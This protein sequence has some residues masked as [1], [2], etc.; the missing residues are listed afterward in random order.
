M[1]LGLGL[2]RREDGAADGRGPPF[3][4]REVCERGLTGGGDLFCEGLDGD[5]WRLREEVGGESGGRGADTRG[6]GRRDGT[7]AAGCR[8]RAFDREYAGGGVLEP[9][10]SAELADLLRERL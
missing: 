10:E 7:G 2:R 6:S 4:L 8:G 9:L 5:S 3:L 1:S